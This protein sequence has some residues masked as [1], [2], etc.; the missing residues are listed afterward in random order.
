MTADPIPE[1]TLVEAWSQL[2]ANPDAVMIDV[3]TKAEWQYVGTPDLASIGR[4]V[5]LVEWITYP[6]GAPN[7]AFLTEATS[8]LHPDQPVLV[9]CRSGVRSLAAAR[10]LREAGFTR[11][12]NITAG[13]EGDLGADG[14][15]HGGWK[16]TLPWHQS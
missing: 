2:N 13:F 10:A 14:H 6:T 4:D 1:L 11:S 8:G 3:R 9:L 12:A 16:E 7:A 15:R 5:R